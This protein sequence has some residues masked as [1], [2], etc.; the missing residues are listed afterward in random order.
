MN[1]TSWRPALRLESSATLAPSFSPSFILFFFIP[2]LLPP[3]PSSLSLFLF[4]GYCVLVYYLHSFPPSFLPIIS[5]SPTAT[6][7]F[8]SSFI[9]FFHSS[10][11]NHSDHFLFFTPLLFMFFTLFIPSLLRLFPRTYCFSPF[12]YSSF[13]LP[14]LS[15]LFAHIYCFHLSSSFILPSLLR[16]ALRHSFP[17]SLFLVHIVLVQRLHFLGFLLLLPCFAFLLYLCH[18]LQR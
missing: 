11:L 10:L 13:F 15:L 6:A 5:S 18:S 14:S 17:S 9:F 1:F 16:L 12:L 3:F 8:L 7:C 2:S 4:F